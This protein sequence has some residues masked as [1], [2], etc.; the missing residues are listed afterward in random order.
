MVEDEAEEEVEEVD[1]EE[2]DEEEVLIHNQAEKDHHKSLKRDHKLIHGPMK[3]LKMQR[4][5]ILQVHGEMV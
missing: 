5:K 2:D 4:K 3:Q 1:L